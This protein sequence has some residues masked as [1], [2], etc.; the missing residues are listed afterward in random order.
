MLYETRRSQDE[1]KDARCRPGAS[2]LGIR[3]LANV[4]CD[5][6]FDRVTYHRR[7][8]GLRIGLAN[9]PRVAADDR[10]HAASS[11]KQDQG[12]HDGVE[13]GKFDGDRVGH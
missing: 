6:T 4:G 9:P 3:F 11:G 12:D 5:A 1:L 13:E 10:K 8:D 2:N 7:L